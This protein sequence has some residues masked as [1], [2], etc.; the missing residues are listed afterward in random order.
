MYLS[1][2]DPDL[3][4]APHLYMGICKGGS[5]YCPSEHFVD[6]SSQILDWL[7]SQPESTICFVA[8]EA[9]SD[10]WRSL[11]S[12]VMFSDEVI[13][14]LSAL[15]K[16][17]VQLFTYRHRLEF[18]ALSSVT[19]SVCELMLCC[20]DVVCGD[21]V[22]MVG[23]SEWERGYVPLGGVCELRV[24]AGLE[25]K[26]MWQKSSV[27]RVWDAP[28]SWNIRM[29]PA[30]A[31]LRVLKDQQQIQLQPSSVGDKWGSPARRWQPLQWGGDHL[32]PQRLKTMALV[33]R[34]AFSRGGHLSVEKK[35]RSS[36]KEQSWEMFWSSRSSP[37]HR[38][39]SQIRQLI[40]SWQQALLLS[41]SPSCVHL[42]SH[43]SLSLTHWLAP[44]T[45]SHGGEE[46][47]VDVS[48]IFPPYKLVFYWLGLGME[49]VFLCSSRSHLI[50]RI[51]I[52][53]HRLWET[54]QKEQARELMNQIRFICL[55]ADDLERLKSRAYES[56]MRFVYFRKDGTLRVISSGDR[57]DYLRMSGNDFSADC[58]VVESVVPHP[59]ATSLWGCK[60]VVCSMGVYGSVWLK[61]QFLKVVCQES[62]GVKGG[63]SVVLK[64]LVS[65]GWLMDEDEKDWSLFVTSHSDSLGVKG[66]DDHKRARWRVDDDFPWGMPWHQVVHWCKRYAQ[67]SHI[68]QSRHREASLLSEHML[69]LA[70]L[71]ALIMVHE[72]WV[73]HMVEADELVRLCLGVP[74]R[75]GS[76]M[77]KFDMMGVLMLTE[78]AESEFAELKAQAA[79]KGIRDEE[80]TQRTQSSA[81]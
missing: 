75:Y 79:I 59:S 55:S 71:L 21:P 51:E 31:L 18:W 32:N 52:L 4:E 57:R 68:H 23:F 36:L 70:V 72:G 6:W 15:R 17:F 47:W 35:W 74:T 58:G 12:Y 14:H 80:G 30:Q 33:L 29:I 2:H 77:A 39:D 40:T 22:S 78:Y 62:A 26:S 56:S 63:V 76:L 61:G 38:S 45:H 49:V 69:V 41:S 25:K 13:S 60:L 27:Y 42:T 44:P 34:S 64:Q 73:D 11:R 5:L 8:D 9:A 3:K 53:R 66:R 24:S 54:F 37:H 10:H 7:K 46:L 19:D 81:H 67:G 43:P 20:Q 1:C 48:V 28:R 65:L 16:F 50:R